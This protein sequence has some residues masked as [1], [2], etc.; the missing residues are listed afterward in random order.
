MWLEPPPST[1]GPVVARVLE[2]E[3]LHAIAAEWDRLSASALEENA[4][5]GRA[6]VTAGLTHLGERDGFRALCVFRLQPAGTERL[7]GLFPLRR[8]RFRYAI[9]AP[10]ELG[11]QNPF[12][13][14]GTPLV[15]RDDAPA[16]IDALLSTA[17]EEAGLARNLLLPHIRSGGAFARLLRE[18][19]GRL[20]LQ[21]DLIP[22]L[23]RP[24]LIRREE[25]ADAYFTRSVAPKRLRELRRTH[26][27]LSEQGILEHRRVTDP[28]EL[29]MA[30]EDFLHIELGGWKGK[31]GTA[32]LSRPQT[33]AFARAAFAGSSDDGAIASADVLSLDGRAIAVSL[34]LQVGR[35]CC[36]IKC[37]YDETY[38]RFSPGLVLELLVIEHLFTTRFADELDSCVTQPGHVI[39]DLWDGAVEVGTLAVRPSASR[40]GIGPF[41]LDLADAELRRT[42]LR[43]QAK[44]HYLAAREKLA[45]LRAVM[46]G[47]EG[48]KAASARERLDAKSRRAMMTINTAQPNGE[49]AAVL[50]T[51]I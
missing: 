46:T 51:M 37:A 5:Y 8:T 16:A 34:N 15:D 1:G 19:A 6:L 38:R 9:P 41:G 10:V 11:A 50:A 21:V 17:H 32:L 44:T 26:R 45:T 39:Q 28:A 40:I 18:R 4:F 35:S 36:A 2:P 48:G 3:A 43:R 23:D 13:T 20:G 47:D 7:I 22:A 25:T 30:V 12:Q 49:F 29:R 27:R 14:S 24:V 31:A 42:E 33:A